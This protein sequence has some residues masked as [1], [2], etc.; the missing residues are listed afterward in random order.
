MK[1]EAWIWGN[2]RL[3]KFKRLVRIRES[4]PFQLQLEFAGRLVTI[5]EGKLVCLFESNEPHLSSPA[6]QQAEIQ[7][8]QS[9]ASVSWKAFKLCEY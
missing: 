5:Q 9:A 1:H 6:F 8:L 3:L 2:Q 7:S 4:L